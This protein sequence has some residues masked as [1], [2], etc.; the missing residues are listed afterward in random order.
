MLYIFPRTVDETD[1]PRNNTPQNSNIEA[2]ITACF[3]VIDLE[4]TDV[5]YY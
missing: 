5:A 3:R 4:A 2:I 1:A